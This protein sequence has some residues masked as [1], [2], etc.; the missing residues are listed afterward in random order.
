M[1]TTQYHKVLRISLLVCVCALVFES[2]VFYG[3]TAEW[4]RYTER[5][6]ASAVGVRASVP[7]TPLNQQTTALSA[8]ER[9][10][11]NREALVREREIQLQQAGVTVDSS[12]YS[13]FI[14][15]ALLFIILVL[16]VLNYVLDFL[17]ARESARWEIAPVDSKVVSS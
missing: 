15:S 4:A 2:G 9:E 8:W 16:L 17:R 5:Y 6:M 10:L 13:T 12:S 1:Q 14:L 3:P 7:L 11:A